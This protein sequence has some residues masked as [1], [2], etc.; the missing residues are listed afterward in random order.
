MFVRV[1]NG[2]QGRPVCVCVCVNS[3]RALCSHYEDGLEWNEQRYAC[4]A[5]TAILIKHLGLSGRTYLYWEMFIKVRYRTTVLGPDVHLISICSGALPIY[6][7]HRGEFFG[8]Y[9]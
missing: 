2:E 1:H 9:E 3:N 5:N 4:L 7:F 8:V 6:L